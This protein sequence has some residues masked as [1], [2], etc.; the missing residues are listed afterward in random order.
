MPHA[1]VPVIQESGLSPRDRQR[2]GLIARASGRLLRL[3]NSLLDFASVEA[4][5]TALSFRPV[6][7][8]KYT[9]DLASLFRSAAERIGIKYIVACEG[10]E[11]AWTDLT[12]YEKIIYNL[13]SNALKYT[14]EGTIAVSLKSTDTHFVLEVRVS[15]ASKLSSVSGASNLLTLMNNSGRRYGNRDSR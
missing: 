13:I 2:F 1:L 7:L 8:A 6:Y 5:R 11:I 15:V 9:A 12:A 10:D 3:V 4:G 14:T